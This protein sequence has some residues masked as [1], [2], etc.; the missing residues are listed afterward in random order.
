LTAIA[1]G[2]GR[3]GLV[4]PSGPLSSVVASHPRSPSPVGRVEKRGFLFAAGRYSRLPM[5]KRIV[6]TGVTRGLGRALAEEM[7]ATGH[8][9]IGCGRN[10]E[11]VAELVATYGAP[12]RFDAVDITDQKS[13]DAWAQEVLADGAPDLLINNAAVINPPGKLW[14]ID[15][16]RWR[17]VIE[18]NV[19]G[20]VHV[21]RPFIPAMIEKGSGLI[22]NM[23]SGWGR[24]PAENFSAYCSSKA[25]VEMLSDTLAKELPEGV[26]VVTLSPGGVNT[27][28]GADAGNAGLGHSVDEWANRAVP[29]I[30]SLT[31][32]QSGE[33]LSVP[34]PE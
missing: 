5:K 2:D 10:A 29:Y 27:D 11:H 19:L 13:V 25:A 21:L 23:S 3:F 33:K 8:T 12:H 17:S 14:E 16:A 7:I 34:E 1:F 31:S 18:V 4:F 32:D 26:S 22:V 15:P 28:M 20:M 9:I 24:F 6:I 30:L